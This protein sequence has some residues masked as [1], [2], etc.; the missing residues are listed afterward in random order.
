MLNRAPNSDFTDSA[1][2][3]GEGIDRDRRAVTGLA[4]GILASA[5]LSLPRT[6]APGA[7]G[8]GIIGAAQA[9]PATPGAAPVAPWWPSKW[10]KDDQIGATNLVTPEKIL[11]ALKLVKAGKLYEMSHLYESS[12]PM[13]G[14][15]S[16]TL[17]IPG[18]PTGGPLGANNFVYHDEF[19][20][21]EIG[22]VGT[23]L[24]GL[25]HIGMAFKGEDKNEMRF[26]N[27][28]TEVEVSD[29]NGLKKLGIE[30]VK[31][32]ITPGHL[33]DLVAV[34]GR[35]LNLGEEI[36]VADLEAAMARQRMAADAVKPGDCVFL[37]TGWGSFWNKD[38]ATFAKGE[39]GIGIPAARWFIDKQVVLIGAD[40]WGVE[41]VPNPDSSLAFPVHQELITKNGIHIH[42]NLDTSALAADGVWTFCYIMLPL[43]IKGAT[44]SPGRPV[45]LV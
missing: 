1:A 31:P 12:M 30:H 14:Q 15:R 35:N 40:T 45:A 33:F 29:A 21:G 5:I 18:G 23:Q 7:D 36:T 22:Q 43:L 4:A 11:D 42:E 34:K 16:F 17:R 26:Y 2:E 13:F 8:I 38:N 37:H 19:V 24:D 28:F 10:G 6:T 3:A 25:G 39:P 27:G 32:I 41:V 9:Q 44:G 20:A